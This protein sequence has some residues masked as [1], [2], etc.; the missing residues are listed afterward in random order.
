MLKLEDFVHEPSLFKNSLNDN[1]LSF[2]LILKHFSWVQF[3]FLLTGNCWAVTWKRNLTLSWQR[4]LPYRNQYIDLLHKSMD[5]FLIEISVM[6]ELVP[7]CSQCILYLL[8]ENI[9]K[10]YDFLMFLVGRERVYWAGQWLLFE[11]MPNISLKSSLTSRM[12][13]DSLSF[14][15]ELFTFKLTY[16]SLLTKKCHLPTLPVKILCSIMHLTQYLQ[17]S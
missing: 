16:L 7:I 1:C 11:L 5:W 13:S 15:R 8:S 3:I 10:A 9:G 6:K 12:F 4:S 2:Y 17:M 14:I